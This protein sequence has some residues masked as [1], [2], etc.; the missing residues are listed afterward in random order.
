MED[1]RW[2]RRVLDACRSELEKAEAAEF[3][4]PDDYVADLKRVIERLEQ[5]LARSAA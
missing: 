2:L 3:P 1:E 4:P 5:R